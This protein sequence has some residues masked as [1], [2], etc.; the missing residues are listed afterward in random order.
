M[1]W[2][3]VKFNLYR[4]FLV[5]VEGATVVSLFLNIGVLFLLIYPRTTHIAENIRNL[6]LYT[7]N[8]PT[9]FKVFDVPGILIVFF[10]Y[11]AFY[12]FPNEEVFIGGLKE[13]I[14]IKTNELRNIARYNFLSILKGFF[15]I[16]WFMLISGLSYSALFN[17]NLGQTTTIYFKIFFDT[18]FLGVSLIMFVSNF[19]FLIESPQ[20]A[21]LDFLLV[22]FWVI[23]GH[24]LSG[25]SLS[26]I[27]R[28]INLLL[29]QI[30]I[31]YILSFP[32][33][34]F[35]FTRILFSILQRTF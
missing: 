25:Q 8:F 26:L 7:I 23:T 35:F 30:A 4:L 3:G 17:V 33:K 31:I 9:I 28:K 24:I 12:L 11:Y 29:F 32:L 22:V 21:L 1:Y 13:V 19:A 2:K 15:V 18:A 20:I 5:L 34:G 27:L 10:I 14:S 6:S 16:F